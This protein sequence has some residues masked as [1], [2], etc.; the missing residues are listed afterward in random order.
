MLL[1]STTRKPKVDKDGLGK[2]HYSWSIVASKFADCFNHNSLPYR[3]ISDVQRINE[4]NESFY[5]VSSEDVHLSF[6]PFELLRVCKPTKNIAHIAWEFPRFPSLESIQYSAQAP[7]NPMND[8]ANSAL[9][10]M[11][12]IWVGCN[13]TKNTLE[14]ITQKPVYCIPAPIFVKGQRPLQKKGPKK[15]YLQASKH[16]KIETYPL[17]SMKI[18]L[19]RM[20]KVG[21]RFATLYDYNSE[22]SLDYLKIVQKVHEAGG[23]IFGCILNPHDW[24]KNLLNMIRGFSLSLCNSPNSVLILKFSCQEST[25]GIYHNMFNWLLG[26]TH[27]AFYKNVYFV[28]DFIAVEHLGCFLT[29]FDFYLCTSNCEGQNLPL[30]EAMYCG[31]VP[32][33]TYNT[34]MGDYINS[35]NSFLIESQPEIIDFTTHP[36]S[37]YWGLT[38]WRSTP[39]QIA[40][41]IN[42]ALSADGLTLSKMSRNATNIVKSSYSLELIYQKVCSALNEI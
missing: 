30:L 20:L 10:Q 2:Q 41:A 36:G 11:D 19:H 29:S 8:F 3:F 23:K 25:P 17:S 12:Q 39:L 34:A 21:H 33:S 1:I 14:N 32:V 22:G 13:F 28:T 16:A 35:S 26:H 24:R 18:K 40:A 38:W 6:A 4:R 42:E 7:G 5:N 15:A 27:A 31:V 9:Q 37:L